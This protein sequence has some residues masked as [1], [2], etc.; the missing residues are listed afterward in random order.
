MLADIQSDVEKLVAPIIEDAGL[1]L[2]EV[3]VLQ[4]RG[5]YEIE[6]LIDRPLGLGHIE[7]EECAAA[8][9]KIAETFDL[10]Q[11]WADNYELV[12]ASPGLDRLLKNEKDFR[13]LLNCEV[14]V[15]LKE[16]VDGKGEYIG[17]VKD[18][19]VGHVVLGLKAKDVK[20]PLDK[21]MKA[22]QNI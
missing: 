7:L 14:R 10:T 19:V 13:R 18:V 17:V 4:K 6:V 9:K 21:I 11:S 12:V 1:D 2:I 3:I 16:K 15:L 5:T 20:I 8:N 22:V